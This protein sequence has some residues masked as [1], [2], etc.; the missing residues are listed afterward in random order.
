MSDVL[1]TVRLKAPIGISLSTLFNFASIWEFRVVESATFRK[2]AKLNIPV[3]AYR[4]M[5]GE[6]PKKGV[7]ELV[8]PLNDFLESMTITEISNV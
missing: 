5:F 2:T 3:N 8:S 7:V 6:E 4:R 1:V